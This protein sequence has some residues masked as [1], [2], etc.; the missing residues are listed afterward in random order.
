MYLVEV[1]GLSKSYGSKKALDAVSL[2]LAEGSITGLVGPNGAGKTT[3]IKVV[4]GL[5]L[6]DAG[7]VEVFGQ[8][9]WDNE[10][11]RGRIGVVYEKAFFP[12][13]QNILEYLQR[14]CRIF[15]VAES[16]ALDILKT[17]DLVDHR[18]QQV[19]S[20]SKGLLQRFSI[21]HA[22]VHNP[23]LIIADEMTANL[24]P[25]VRASILDLVLQLQ[26]EQ[27]VTFLISSHILPELSQVCDSLLIINKGRVVASGKI[28]D[29]YE[30]YA[31]ATVRISAEKTEEL[32]REISKLPYVKKLTTNERDISI[33]VE[34]GKEQ[35]LY[36]DASTL[37]RKIQVK[38]YGIETANA[39]IEEL[40]KQAVQ[41]NNEG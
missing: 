34:T 28:S 15:G 26:K 9:P 10:K 31:A 24:D 14:C 2:S 30:K 16:R 38:I 40:Y 32:S 13:H 41:P 5:L 17:V 4:L 3:A 11:I 8:N 1:E 35:N 12:P 6:P 33:I 18:H 39:S 21:G 23:K 37:A 29:L 20:L 19:K 22:L 25:Q 27:N 7:R 36:E